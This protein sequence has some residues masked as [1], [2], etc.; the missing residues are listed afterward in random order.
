VI[1]ATAVSLVDGN[2]GP[3]AA[4]PCHHCE[5]E[6]WL[7]SEADIVSLGDHVGYGPIL[8]QKS[9]ATDLAVGPFVESRARKRCP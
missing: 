5:D 9:A 6:V 4:F 8:L 1:G 2:R 7:P 3:A